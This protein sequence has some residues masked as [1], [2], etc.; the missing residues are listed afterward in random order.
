MFVRN[1]TYLNK[2]EASVETM[3]FEKQAEATLL[4]TYI[5]L[6][7][8]MLSF[9]ED[10]SVCIICKKKGGGNIKQR[11]RRRRAVKRQKE[12]ANTVQQ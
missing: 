11:V 4:Y 7:M 5:C 10:F 8:Y 3:H 9:K 2:Q 12:G 6:C 1:D